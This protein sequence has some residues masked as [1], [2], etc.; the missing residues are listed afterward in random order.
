MRFAIIVDDQNP[1]IKSWHDL[2][3]KPPMKRR[4]ENKETPSKGT[5]MSED[6]RKSANY[7]TDP[8]REDLFNRGMA[9]IY[10]GNQR[11]SKTVSR[12]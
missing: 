9:L 5:R 4:D 7:L 6:I 8:E 11:A 10:G 12:P 1:F 2:S 3:D